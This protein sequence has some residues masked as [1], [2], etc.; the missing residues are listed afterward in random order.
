MHV[1]DCASAYSQKDEAMLVQAREKIVQDSPLCAHPSDLCFWQRRIDPTPSKFERMI[2]C[3]L[4]CT[5]RRPSLRKE[6]AAYAGHVGPKTL[7]YATVRGR[8]IHCGSYPSSAK[9]SASGQAIARRRERPPSSLLD[10]VG[11]PGLLVVCWRAWPDVF[12]LQNPIL[13][14]AEV[15]LKHQRYA[16]HSRHFVHGTAFNIA[17][18]LPG[19]KAMLAPMVLASVHMPVRIRQNQVVP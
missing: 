10:N 4:R 6:P 1:A 17:M 15:W 19:N 12:H 16:T 11:R 14:F 2:A 3:Y 5:N 7:H 9:R 18:I 13:A 8:V